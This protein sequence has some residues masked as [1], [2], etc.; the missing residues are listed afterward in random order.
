MQQLLTDAG[1]HG[2]K[3]IASLGINYVKGAIMGVMVPMLTDALK[4]ALDE[5]KSEVKGDEKAE[6]KGRQPLDV[7]LWKD[8]KETGLDTN[9]LHLES[10]PT[11][12]VW[13]G[14]EWTGYKMYTVKFGTDKKSN[15]FYAVGYDVTLR[16]SNMRQLDAGVRKEFKDAKELTALPVL[17]PDCMHGTKCFCMVRT[18]DT[19]AQLHLM[20][21]YVEAL[22][23]KPFCH[24]KYAADLFR[25]GDDYSSQ[26]LLKAVFDQ[27]VI[28]T[29]E[30]F[31][32][33]PACKWCEFKEPFDEAEAIRQ[34]LYLVVSH[35]FLPRLRGMV[36][37]PVCAANA[38]L[39]AESALLGVLN[40]AADSWAASMDAVN[41]L[42]SEALKAVEEAGATLIEKLK[43]HLI[44]VL[45]KVNSKMKKGGE[46]KEE[47]KPVPQKMGDV[48]FTWNFHRTPI[49]S[50][51]HTAM[52]AGKAKEAIHAAEPELNPRTVLEAELRG[53]AEAIGGDGMADVPGIKEAIA[54]LSGKMNEQIYRFNTLQPLLIAVQSLATVRDEGEAALGAA[55]GKPEEIAKAIDAQSAA[56]WDNG[57]TKSVMQMFCE[58]TRIRNSVKVAYNGDTPEKAATAMIDF[59]DYLFQG[60]VR[61]LNAVRVRYITL[62][63]GFL[64]G[65][66]IAD[67]DVIATNSK[68]AFRQAFFEVADILVD[69]F[70]VNMCQNIVLFACATAF[71][72]FDKEVWPSMEEVLEPIKSILPEP[73]AKANV[74]TK[75]IKMII[76]VVIDKAM[77]FITTKLLIFAEKKLF[78][79]A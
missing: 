8:E 64:V 23:K 75:I 77:T 76:K 6:S 57:L 67:K 41:K 60:H 40:T 48:T 69:D 66:A 47:E 26:A 17:P 36:N 3:V 12:Y 28:D 37:P 52:G 78:T 25:I 27:A 62:L 4:E 63:R 49:G 22:A 7:R 61:A 20:R 21:P 71:A 70:W 50:K 5:A 14:P 45:E 68:T 15:L 73:V 59:V 74:H 65:D 56:L 32:G 35:E 39:T 33:R 29:V 11:Q 51:L 38:R 44:K 46:K 24:S 9:C 18:V 34:L 55:A 13:F 19:H 43:P 58:Y 79:Q 30:E 53:I 1:V 72:K 10:C 2:G 54:E 42:K 16:H 31:L